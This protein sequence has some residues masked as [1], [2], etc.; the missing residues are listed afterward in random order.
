MGISSIASGLQQLG[1]PLGG[2]LVGV[3][4]GALLYLTLEMLRRAPREVR[5]GNVPVR[6]AASLASPTEPPE[7]W[8]GGNEPRLIPVYFAGGQR[9]VWMVGAGEHPSLPLPRA[10]R[11][12]AVLA[13]SFLVV[14]VILLASYRLVFGY[15]DHLVAL[16]G[17]FLYWPLAWPGVYAV[18]INVALVPDYVFPMYLAGMVA[19]SVATG[20]WTAGPGQPARRRGLGAAV[21]LLYVGVELVLDALLFT[22]PGSTF[23]DLGLLIRSLNGG[24][25]FALL[26]LCAIHLPPAQELPRRF[27]RDRRAIVA[28]F[29]VAL[30]SLG[31][32]AVLL[33][34]VRFWLGSIS[35]GLSLTTL[36]LVPTVSLEMFGLL[37]RPLY[38]RRLRQRPVP[39][40]SE[41]HPAVSIL[42]PAYNEAEWIERTIRSAD[43]AAAQYPGTVQ[44]IVGN[45]GS[46]DETLALARGAIE[47]LDHSV[48]IVID[49]PH[50]GKSSALNGALAVA[51]GD[52]VLRLDGDT[53]ISEAFGFHAMIPHFADPEVGAVQGGVHPRQRDGWTRKLRALEIAWNHYLLRPG[54]MATRT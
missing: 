19:F 49:L 7:D 28:F 4:L 40:L 43:R 34:L 31:A 18:G 26:T 42:I 41:Y 27:P 10:R 53:Q 3:G 24:L 20:L 30:L 32:A 37:S 38:A 33:E 14:A 12:V 23:R 16:V 2:L 50:G 8:A 1:L 22:V 29:A 17:T 47:R 5:P 45:D 48:G 46:T 36:L 39:S 15:Y 51:T 9:D 52:I 54:G 44:I 6:V 11:F 13:G 25:F 35:I 21:L